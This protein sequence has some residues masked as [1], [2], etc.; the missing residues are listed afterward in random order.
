M[1]RVEGGFIVMVDVLQIFALQLRE[2]L[3]KIPNFNCNC[4]KSLPISNRFLFLITSYFE[5][6]THFKSPTI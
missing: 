3:S 2:L 5:I 4:W 1:H 6:A